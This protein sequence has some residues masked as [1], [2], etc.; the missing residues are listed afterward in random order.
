[1]QENDIHEIETVDELAGKMLPTNRISATA[2]EVD[3]SQYSHE[4]T[5]LGTKRLDMPSTGSVDGAAILSAYIRSPTNA[6]ARY[7]SL[8]SYDALAG[9]PPGSALLIVK[10]KFSINYSISM[11]EVAFDLERFQLRGAA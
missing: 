11:A 2:F 4:G 9:E 5:V 7:K 1:M 8:R 3:F 10:I 6:H